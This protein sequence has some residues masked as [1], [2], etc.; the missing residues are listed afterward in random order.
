[1]RKNLSFEELV[2]KGQ[3]YFLPSI[4]IDNVIFGFHEDELK[5]LLLYAKE[6]DKW[7]LPGGFIYNDEELE[8]AACRILKTRTGLDKLFLQQFQAFGDTKRSNNEVIRG[9]LA[10]EFPKIHKDNWLF[11]RFLTIGYYA[12]VDYSKVAP[13]PDP[14]STKC[15]WHDLDK[16]PSLMM[17]HKEIVRSALQSLRLQ[18]NYKPIGYNLLP[19]EFTLKSLQVIYETILGRKL[20]RSNFNRKILSLGILEKREKQYTGAAHKAP[21]LYAFDKKAYFK[22]LENGLEREF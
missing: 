16:L 10:K 13:Q 2:T 12:L 1:M 18:L 22:A 7:M 19:K 4:S 6:M 20:D 3:D 17:D 8:E 5:V 14:F 21:F 9:V 11:Q 15:E